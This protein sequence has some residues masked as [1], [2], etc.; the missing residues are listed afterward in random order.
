LQVDVEILF[1]DFHI[2]VSVHQASP[3][4]LFGSFS[5]FVEKMPFHNA[6]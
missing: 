1:L 6:L 5:F 3:F 2:D 4:L